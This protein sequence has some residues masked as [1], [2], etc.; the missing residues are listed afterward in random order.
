MYVAP[1]PK[2]KN[3]PLFAVRLALGCVCALLVAIAI[4]SKMPML[5]PS[6]TVGLMAGMRKTYDIKKAVGGPLAL[7]VII[8]VFYVLMS[9]L[10]VMPVLSILVVFMLSTLSYLI[11]LKTG[12]PIGMLLLISLTLMSVMGAKSLPAMAV[13]QEGFIEGALTAFIIIPILYWLLPSVAKEPL[14]E[15]YVPDE[16]GYH[17]QRAM[18]RSLVMILLLAWLYTVLDTSNM[19]LAMAAVFSLVFPTKEHQ[20]DEAKERSM[21]TAIGGGFALLILGLSAL[22]GHLIILLLLIFLVALLLGDRMMHGRQPPMVNQFALSVMV[23][24][25]VGGLTNQEPI[26][27]TFL[28]VSLTLV[29]AVGA[30]YLSALLENLFLPHFRVK[31]LWAKNPD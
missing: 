28:R 17:L 15:E 25:T 20:F 9:L 8:S 11:I 27:S 19:I 18:I 2:A 26:S 21:A 12:N 10:H 16:H 24:L 3:D 4:Q 30:A 23:A 29:G 6:L 22:M 31:A 7:I 1:R 5:L 14:V 13:I